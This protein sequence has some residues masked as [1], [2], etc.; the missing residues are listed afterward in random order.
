MSL[1]YD[2]QGNPQRILA[3][4]GGDT[5]TDTR[6][7]DT[8]ATLNAQTIISLAQETTAV[9]DVR[10]TFVGTFV[11][12][13]SYDG[14][15]YVQ[16]PIFNPL[17]ELYV[18][19][20]TAPGQFMLEIPGGS[21]RARVR[22]SAYTSG[23]S[24]V[25]F[26]AVSAPEFIY[27]K[28]LPAS[29]ISNTGAAGAAV[30]LTIPSAGVGLYNYLTMLQ[31]VKFS[32]ALLV[33]AATPVLVTTAGI[34]GTPVFSFPADASVQGSVVEQIFSFSKPVKGT[35]T[36]TAMTVVCPAITGVIWRV[37]ASFYIGA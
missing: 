33:P 35:L 16:Y 37:N 20:I 19:G 9:I 17:T 12:E 25:T 23:F 2:E 27:A 22:C 18:T 29:A 24:F 5:V 14:I 34:I 36:N 15:N 32:A 11:A 28:D 13:I 8:L 31:I 21:Y 3:A 10:G 6:S 7:A 30:T 1:I 26:R 4:Q